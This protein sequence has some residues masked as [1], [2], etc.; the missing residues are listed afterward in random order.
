MPGHQHSKEKK[1]AREF[2][3]K[4]FSIKKRTDL[5][6]QDPALNEGKTRDVL[7]KGRQIGQGGHVPFALL[8]DLES[9]IIRM[10]A[11]RAILLFLSAFFLFLQVLVLCPIF[12]P[13][14]DKH[15]T[16]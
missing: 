16:L 8:F 7:P 10:S 4:A 6:H 9:N 1:R 2:A 13:S 11:T 14:V 15:W 5:G 3:G 12:F